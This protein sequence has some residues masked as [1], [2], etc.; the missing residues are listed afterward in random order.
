MVFV[1]EK[2]TLIFVG[3]VHQACQASTWLRSIPL[4]KNGVIV[5]EES[6]EPSWFRR[7]ASPLADL[8][9]YGGYGWDR[10]IQRPYDIRF[11][12]VMVRV[13][14]LW[15]ILAK[16]GGMNDPNASSFCKQSGAL[17]HFRIARK[18]HPGSKFRHVHDC[19]NLVG[20]NS[21]NRPYVPRSSV[22]GVPQRIEGNIKI[23]GGISAYSPCT[24]LVPSQMGYA[25][26]QICHDLRKTVVLQASVQAKG[27]VQVGCEPRYGRGVFWCSTRPSRLK[28]R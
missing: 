14:G 7:R 24:S 11:E 4:Q 27:G 16:N 25:F 8:D 23:G 3:H 20:S 5:L 19:K 2:N 17:A 1:K 28:T 9:D 22:G 18:T 13:C 12:P 26:A 10:S 21:Q 6:V 15:G